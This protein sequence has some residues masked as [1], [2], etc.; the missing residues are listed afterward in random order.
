[1]LTA[2]LLH[3]FLVYFGSSTQPM[4][5]NDN[6]LFLHIH[7]LFRASKLSAEYWGVPHLQANKTLESYIYF[8]LVK[9]SKLDKKKGFKNHV[10]KS[11]VVE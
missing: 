4:S 8:T 3:I 10:G 7:N 11:L 1:M 2:I 5:C 6:K 9:H